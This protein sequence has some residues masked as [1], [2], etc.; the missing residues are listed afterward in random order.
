LTDSVE[1]VESRLFLEIRLHGSEIFGL[2]WLPLQIDYEHLGL[3]RSRIVRS[4]A[5]PSRNEAYGA[6]KIA[7]RPQT[8]FFNRIGPERTCRA[9]HE[10]ST[11]GKA[12]RR[13]Y[14]Y[15]T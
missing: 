5:S 11:F 6:E 7:P 4:P 12:G 2:I 13:V 14:E 8:G 15:A 1:K 10:M 3:T 9:P